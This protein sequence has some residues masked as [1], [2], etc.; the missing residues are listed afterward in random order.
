MPEALTSWSPE[1]V[2]LVS[3]EGGRVAS[4]LGPGLPL[5]WTLSIQAKKCPGF[6]L[7]CGFLPLLPLLFYGTRKPELMPACALPSPSTWEGRVVVTAALP[8]LP[9]LEQSQQVPGAW[10]Q[11]MT[12]R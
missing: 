7:A 10:R 2:F 12:P 11:Q 3:K 8:G 4:A 6:L 5:A 9:L 1:G